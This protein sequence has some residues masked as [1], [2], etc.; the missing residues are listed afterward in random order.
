M[1]TII[2]EDCK[3]EMYI[4]SYILKKFPNLSK[5]NLFKAL[6]NKDIKV[7][8]K[9][10]NKDVVVNQN[11]KIQIM[12][13]KGQTDTISKEYKIKWERLQWKHVRSKD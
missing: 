13:N 2:V 1:K 6:R 11:D 8:D 9:R 4:S 7:N 12:I 10:I 3:K 5:G